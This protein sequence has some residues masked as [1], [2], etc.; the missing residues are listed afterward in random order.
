MS[1]NLLIQA[2]RRPM[3]LI[4]M[5]VVG[6]TACTGPQSEREAYDP[7]AAT[8]LQ[9]HELSQANHYMVSA[10]NPI[11]VNAGLDILEQGGNA[12]DAA[13]AVQS[14]L[15]LVEPQSS[16][17]GGGAFILYWDAEEQALF[18]LDA[19]E[20]APQAAD[21]SLFL[22][23]SGEAVTWIEAVVGGRSVGTP[24]LM[25]GLEDAHNRWGRLEWP[26]LFESTITLAREGFE[27]SPRLA[28][29]VE[30]EINPGITQLETSKNYF[31]P[32]GEALQAGTIKQN[33]ELADSLHSIAQ[34]GPDAFYYGEMAEQIV[35]AVNTSSIAPG[36]LAAEDL[37]NYQTEWREPVCANYHQHRI[38]SMGPPSSGGITVLQMLRMLEPF[39]LAQYSKDDAEAWHLFTQAS[40]LAFADRDLYLADPAFVHVPVAEML[41]E[42]YLVT[43]SGLIGNQDMGHASP[44]DFNLPNSGALSY[45]QPNTT[46]ISIV[47]SYG[48]AVS[49]TS[50]IEMGFGSAV[51]V[52]GFLLN[53][54]LTDFSLQPQTSEGLAANRVEP[55]KRPRSSM[56][57]VMSFNEKGE[58]EYVVGSPGGPRIINYVA[59]VLVGLI[60][61]ELDMQSAIDLPNVTNLNGRTAIEEGLAP[62]NWQTELEQKDHNIQVRSLNSGIHG[63]M[64]KDGLLFGGADLRREGTAQGQ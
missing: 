28:R 1:A 62:S 59:K 27:V 19:R 35:E 57:P 8:G 18:T 33:P 3:P 55:G 52:G 39:E 20:T 15:T 51:M 40:R 21:Q 31:F 12:I 9:Q 24:G 2:L 47:D 42:D 63:I 4:A 32:Q 45:E 34:G 44:G 61:F 22:N 43:R 13:I 26:A 30:L 60:D 50:T 5:L 54:Q 49:M 17:I 23:D 36:L 6:L 58:L 25:R 29:L 38:C 64:I 37:A 46:H 11:A 41:D 53:N 14:M 56:T 48:N 7:E 10:A 16:G